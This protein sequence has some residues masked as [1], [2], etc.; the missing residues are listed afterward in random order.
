MPQKTK[1]G[2]RPTHQPKKSN[3]KTKIQ[4]RQGDVS[5]MNAEAS[6]ALQYWQKELATKGEATKQKYQEYFKEFLDFIGKNPDELIVQRQQDLLNPDRKIQRRIESELLAFIAQKK[7]NN[8]AVA[9]QQIYFASIR[10]FFDI[11]YF[12]LIMRRGDYPKGD[13][14]GVKRATKDAILK[15]LNNKTRNT[16]TIKPLILFIKDT[17]LRVS[18]VRRLNYGDISRQLENGTIPIQINVITQKTKLLA[19]TFIGE[20]AIH[21]LKEYLEARRKGSRNVE[22]ETVAKNS[23]LFKLWAHGDVKR[24]S[25]HSLSSLLREA[26]VNVNEDRMSAHSLRKKLQTDLEKAGINSNWIDQILGHKLINSR[27]AY[28][29]PTDEELKEAYTKAYQFIRV[30]PEINTPVKETAEQAAPILTEISTTGE[31]NYP[32]AEARNIEQVKA[33]LAKGYKYEMEMEGIKLFV[34]K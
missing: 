34:K 28:S 9:T 33:L 5:A 12:P 15:V 8:Y 19:K 23:P 21:A 13:S 20:E 29:L 24:I 18:D 16:V 32:V 31:E 3:T 7:A 26:F 30:Y 6:P 25:R 4:H 10:S 17:G 22:P 14:N 27:D 1:G 11:H 2:L